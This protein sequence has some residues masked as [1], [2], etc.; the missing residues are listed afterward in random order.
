MGLS[1]LCGTFLTFWEHCDALWNQMY[2]QQ[3]C[4]F[5]DPAFESAMLQESFGWQGKLRKQNLYAG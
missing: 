3:I 2:L 1:G 4:T 5:F